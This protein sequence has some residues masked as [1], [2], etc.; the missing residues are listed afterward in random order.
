[1]PVPG[2]RDD[3]GAD[4]LG[5]GFGHVRI[6]PGRR[7]PGNKRQNAKTSGSRSDQPARIAA[8]TALERHVH[9][10]VPVSEA[11]SNAPC[12]LA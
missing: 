8:R 5:R 2:P 1:L 9:R 7:P 10:S 11:L 4:G 3:C 6:V 12:G